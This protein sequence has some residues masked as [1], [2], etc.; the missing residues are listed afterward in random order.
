MDPFSQIQLADNSTKPLAC[1]VCLGRTDQG[2]EQNQFR[3]PVPFLSQIV[4]FGSFFN[5]AGLGQHLSS[6][7]P[8]CFQ[9]F[10][11]ERPCRL[12]SQK[13]QKKGLI[14]VIGRRP[15]MSFQEEIPPAIDGIIFIQPFRLLRSGSL[16]INPYACNKLLLNF[17]V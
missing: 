16:D 13:I 5:E 10:R 4:Q 2:L 1:V 17:I 12:D 9:H 3:Q 6:L 8:E 7:A 11:F 15:V 14:L